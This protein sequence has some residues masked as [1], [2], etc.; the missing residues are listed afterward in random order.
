MEEQR[1]SLDLFQELDRPSV[2]IMG[3]D[4]RLTNQRA[5][6]N[7]QKEEE[8]PLPEESRNS[9]RSG[10]FVSTGRNKNIFGPRGDTGGGNLATTA[11]KTKFMESE[12]IFD[13]KCAEKVE[14]ENWEELELI[15]VE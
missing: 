14:E 10:S 12:Q 15:A 9:K 1:T 5:Q 13:L 7:S 2:D 4:I 8:G 11:R 3:E 6:Y